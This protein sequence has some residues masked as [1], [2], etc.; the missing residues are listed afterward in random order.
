MASFLSRRLLFLLRRQNLTAY[1][2][3]SGP[4]SRLLSSSPS[5]P[6]L[7]SALPYSR[8]ST[9]AEQNFDSWVSRLSP[10]FTSDDLAMAIRAEPDP[11][12]ALDLFRWASL[13]PRYNHSASSY[14]AALSTAISSRRFAVAESLVDEILAGACP[15]DLPLFNTS[16][17]FC[18]SRRHL[19]SRAFDVYKKM[20]NSPPTCA[21][22]LETY[23]MLL[24]AVIRRL[25]KPPIC[26]IYL[27]SVR[28]LAREL[29][30]SGIIPDTFLLNLIIKAYC[31][32]L[33]IDD[34]LTVFREMPLYNCQPND[35]TYGYLVKGLCEKGRV[36]RGMDMFCEM[37][38]KG[39]VP[40]GG[41]YNVLVSSIALESRFE[42]AIKVVFDMLEN[43]RQPDL[44]T[45]RTLMEGLCR[46]GR[47]EEAFELLEELRKRRGAME[48]QVYSDLL[49][50]LHWIC[51]PNKQQDAKVKDSL[52]Q[53]DSLD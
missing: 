10:G 8:G 28:S 26:Y 2:L 19:F 40:T 36:N 31:R 20:R 12:L 9:H 3:Q 23:T 13:R 45:Y 24:S 18:C 48:R 37:R 22:N 32:C 21:P 47:A 43:K 11:D 27:R 39:H 30:S 29:K 52:N 46:E 25:G 49:D 6:S 35:L 50:G 14:H 17:R 15:P 38:E 4:P 51:Q 53:S 41:V 42:D 44:L 1:P 33:E 7:D 5:T 16:I 34:A